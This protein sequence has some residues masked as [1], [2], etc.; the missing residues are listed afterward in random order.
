MAGRAWEDPRQVQ[1]AQQQATASWDRIRALRA[2]PQAPQQAAAL[3]TMAANYPWMRPGVALPLVQQQVAPDAPLAQQVATAEAKR[4]KK[5][6]GFWGALGDHVISPSRIGHDLFGAAE[7]GVSHVLNPLG[8]AALGGL[9]RTTRLATSAAS[10]VPEVGMGLYRD[11]S[12]VG[13]QLAAGAVGGAGIGTAAGLAGGPFAPITVPVGAA[14]GG[15][16]GG[17]AGAL[18][19]AR[20]RGVES[21]GATNPFA[22]TSFGQQLAGRSLG[23]GYFPGGEARAAAER[24]Q[25]AAASIGGHALTPGRSLAYAVSEPGTTPYNLLSGVMDLGVAWELDPIQHA[26]KGLGAYRKAKAAFVPENMKA[27]A[28]LV[29]GL[30][31]TVLPE[32]I[33]MWKSSRQGAT[34]RQWLADQGDFEAIRQAL[35]RVDVR[36][37]LDLTNAKALDEVDAVLDPALGIQRGLEVKPKVGQWGAGVKRD[38]RDKF[39]ILN[40]LPSGDLNWSD[41]TDAVH[42]FDLLQRDANIAGDVVATNNRKL[43][44]ALLTEGPEGRHKANE[45]VLT[46]FFGRIGDQVDQ[47]GDAGNL[48]RKL[49][50]KVSKDQ[51]LIYTSAVAE[52]GTQTAVKAVSWGGKSTGLP[53]T[54]FLADTV[55]TGMSFDRQTIRDIRT[56]TGRLAPVLSHPWAKTGVSFADHAQS[57]LWKPL[58]LIRGA[59]TVRVIGEE[60][61]RLAASGRMSMFNHPLSYLAWAMDDDSRIAGILNKLPGT[62]TGVGQVGVTGERFAEAGSKGRVSA[63]DAAELELRGAADD[64]AAALGIRQQVEGHLDG[65]LVRSKHQ[66]TFNRGDDDYYRAHAEMLDKLHSD[67]LVRSIA[68]RG[69]EDTRIAFSHPDGDL[70]DLRQALVKQGATLERSADVDAHLA[71]AHT[72]YLEAV[73]AQAPQEGALALEGLPGAADPFLTQAIREGRIGDVPLRDTHS[74]I[75]KD[76]VSALRHQSGPDTLV[77]AVHNAPGNLY[78]AQ[79]DRAVQSMFTHLMAQPSARL[80]RSP[81][82]RQTYWDEAGN[83]VHQLDPAEQAHLLEAAR[84]AKLPRSHIQRLEKRAKLGS[85]DMTVEQAD[86]LLKGRALDATR[87]LLYDV[88]QKGQL[89][90]TLR[91]VMPFMEAQKE[92][93]KVWAKVGTS[94]P[95]VARRAQQVIQGARGAGFFHTDTQTGEEMFTFP[96]SEYLT[97]KVLGLPIQLQGRVSG[98]NMFG[99]GIMPGMGPVVQ[100]PTRWLLPD[101]PQFDELRQ[102]VDPFGA[103]AT[104]GEGILEQNLPS[105][106][107]KLKTALAPSS[108]DRV[109]ANTVKDVWAAG[110]SAGIYSSDTP[111]DIKDGLEDA[112]NK[113]R[114]LYAIRGLAS[115]LGAPT[116]PTPEMMAKDKDGHWLVAS[117]LADDL[118]KMQDEDYE[119]SSAKFLEKYGNNAAAYLQA[120][121]F[122]TTAASPTT[123]D[124]ASWL[125]ANQDVAEKYPEIAGLFAP[126]EGQFSYTQYLRTL[127]SG[128]TVSLTPEQYV[129]Q[130]NNKVGA[131]I[132]YNQRDKMGP[133]P[134]AEQRA[135]LADVRQIL[136]ETL[137]GYGT[138]LPGKPDRDTVIKTFIPQIEKAVADPALAD[139]EVAQATKLYLTARDKALASAEAAGR[140]SFNQAKDMA[141]V[142]EWLRS[143]AEIIGREVPGFRE[144]WERVFSRE[145]VDDTATTGQEVATSG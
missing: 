135:W 119:T 39:R 145:M 101:K 114:G 18:S 110:L 84:E 22:Q 53:R 142:R 144:P 124:A 6:H 121:S 130:A 23:S 90:D 61:I 92:V 118:R 41:P 78:K 71:K 58:Q 136:R 46:E 59:W 63:A 55:D 65:T 2:S 123:E 89:S 5:S 11:I 88:A 108:S 73:G 57:E 14:V 98:L 7:F 31:N 44:E 103:T 93:M 76:F 112:K 4:N 74:R 9:K 126:G 131:M 66:A 109:F 113:A 45:I 62:R 140:P 72:N 10:F 3:S 56:A 49:A 132:Y 86:M 80:S 85:G 116:A 27:E 68:E 13:G 106:M 25:K 29:E 139:N 54:G 81:M 129:E 51:Q 60:Q 127:G 96:G 138:D 143:I 97:E 17:V 95:Q 42:Q 8:G 100:L 36:T 79:R 87:D 75:N 70:N 26:L 77:G 99:S 128:A 67:P 38:M 102:F 16:V 20:G 111:E 137:P 1:A 28:G 122:G 24:S 32:R 141:P 105:Y 48:M 117:I 12:A 35:P 133:W 15:V 107:T 30:R 64:Y 37:V 120:K 94:N 115:V 69:L 83:L 82:F 33:E 43:A 47:A 21:G 50:T 134:S 125:R 104:Q 34:A 91:L 19:E 52:D 40:D